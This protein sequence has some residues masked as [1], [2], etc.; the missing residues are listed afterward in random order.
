MTKSQILT[1]DLT[2]PDF[3][4]EELQPQGWPA[5]IGGRGLNSWLLY[6]GLEQGATPLG[7]ENRLILSAGMLAGT[8]APASSRLHISALSPAS[9]LMGSSNAGGYFA[10]ELALSGLISLQI[11]G[12]AAEPSLLYLIDGQPE[13]RPAGDIWGMETWQAIDALSQGHEG[14]RVQCAV[15]GP[16]GENLAVMAAVLVGKH[17]TAGR[18]GMG[19]VMGSKNLKAV[20]LI[21]GGKTKTQTSPQASALVSQLCKKACARPPTSPK[22]S[23]A[24]QSGYIPWANDMGL[25]GSQQFQG[26]PV[27]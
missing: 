12:R 25:L 6:K 10:Q 5:I 15:T 9:G 11:I 21:S 1:I 2:R 20:V 27:R 8:G 14:K 7:P 23:Q 22:T 3:E 19:A 17:S 24:G 4:F 13:L 16:A 18:T 26:G